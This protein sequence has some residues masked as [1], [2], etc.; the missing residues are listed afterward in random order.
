MNTPRTRSIGAAH[1]GP[2]T[3]HPWARGPLLSPEGDG[4]GAGAGGESTATTGESTATTSEAGTAPPAGEKHLPQS[5]VNVLVANARREGREAALRERP[6]T[7]GKE[8]A[9]KGAETAAAPADLVRQEVS[10]VRTFERAIAPHALNDRQ[11]ARM[12]EALSAANP[13]DVA[14]W[15]I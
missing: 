6:A 8:P 12:E 9:P 1:L 7:P 4:V 15:S 2:A 11:V 14:A 13:S 3:G 5:Q 10:R